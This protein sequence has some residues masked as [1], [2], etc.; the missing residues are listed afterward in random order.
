MLRSTLKKLEIQ[1]RETQ[2]TADKDIRTLKSSLNE[3]KKRRQAAQEEKVER[4][5][6]LLQDLLEKDDII[7]KLQRELQKQQFCSGMLGT[8][9]NQCEQTQ[10]QSILDFKSILHAGN[11][12]KNALSPLRSLDFGAINNASFTL[13]SNKQLHPLRSSQQRSKAVH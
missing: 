1:L 5:N 10:N 2:V 11:I 8:P 7:F 9:L 6:R 3:E 13:L 4:N 12:S